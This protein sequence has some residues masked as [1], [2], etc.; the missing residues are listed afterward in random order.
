MVLVLRSASQ[1]VD[2]LTSVVQTVGG[3]KT[4]ASDLE[5]RRRFKGRQNF[6]EGAMP[7]NRVWFITMGLS[8]VAPLR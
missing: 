3:G 5:V 6:G 1:F 8:L 7:F 4:L 2:Q